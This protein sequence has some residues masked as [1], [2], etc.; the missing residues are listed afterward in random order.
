[1]PRP[2]HSHPLYRV[3]I[4][5]GTA[6]LRGP[7]VVLVW[8]DCPGR[9]SLAPSNAGVSTVWVSWSLDTRPVW[10]FRSIFDVER[11]GSGELGK[12]DSR[13]L[14]HALAATGHARQ[15]VVALRDGRLTLA[16]LVRAEDDMDAMYRG[17]C[18]VDEGVRQVPGIELG[19][20][21]WRAVARTSPSGGYGRAS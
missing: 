21:H 19:E 12:V 17:L 8:P 14:Q 10:R 15:P 20:L 16:M 5:E 1:M 2:L 7:F 13:Q 3:R 6:V 9:G 18:I 4:T 11:I